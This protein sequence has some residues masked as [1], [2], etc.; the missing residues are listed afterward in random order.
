MS[1]PWSNFAWLIASLLVLL[2]LNRWITIH[3]QGVGFLLSGNRITAIWLYFFLFLPGIMLHELS[4]YLMA[5]FLQVRVSRFSLWPRLQGKRNL[6]LGSVEVQGAGPLRH[7]L[8]GVAPLLFGSLVVVLIGRLLQFDAVGAALA[9]GD[10]SLAFDAAG[11]S[12]L[13]PDFWLWLY[14]LFAVANAML[15]SPSD[16][17]YWGPVLLFIGAMIVLGLGLDI[18]PAIPAGAQTAA[19]N[20]IA[21]MASA[22]SIAAAV[23]LLFVGL[24]LVLETSIGL[25]TG[26]RIQY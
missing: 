20:F 23:D 21:F 22:L 5:L 15:P 25:A 12:F 7:S 6:V 17:L 4:H 14:L 19:S 16:R 2:L 8:V 1:A 11:Q 9:E 18:L 24:I 3:V 26:R 10:L 13:T